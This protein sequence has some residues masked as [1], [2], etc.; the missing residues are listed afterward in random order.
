MFN[1]SLD[2]NSNAEMFSQLE[3]RYKKDAQ[4]EDQKKKAESEELALNGKPVA[5]I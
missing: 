5:R 3:K 2:D 1:Q 4:A